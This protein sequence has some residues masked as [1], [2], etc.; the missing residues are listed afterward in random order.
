MEC[1][2]KF[3]K[4]N[5]KDIWKTIFQGTF[6]IEMQRNL[7]HMVG[8]DILTFEVEG[9]FEIGIYKNLNTDVFKGPV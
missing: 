3:E 1:Q 8:K 2:I 4:L 6:T 9:H 7:E 5:V